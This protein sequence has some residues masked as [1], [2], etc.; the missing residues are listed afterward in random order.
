MNELL[1][2]TNKKNK[3]PKTFIKSD[4]SN[5]IEDPV[6]TANKFNDYFINIGPNLAKKIKSDNN[7]TFEEYLYGSYQSSL[8][9]NVITENELETELGNMKL[10]TSSGFDDVNTKI[11]KKIAKEISKPLTHI[12][13]LSFST[14]IVPDKLKI[15]LI[16]PI[17]KVM[18][19]TSL[20]ITNQYRF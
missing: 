3:L 19:K 13:N 16:T 11:I 1:N 17:F 7:D 5:I 4:S 9:L 18:K 8:F 10:N 2:K 6:K 15:S 20:K 14:G 12:F